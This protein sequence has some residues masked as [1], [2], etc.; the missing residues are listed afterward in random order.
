MRWTCWLLLMLVAFVLPSGCARKA[1]NATLPYGAPV[2]QI[3]SIQVEYPDVETPAHDHI[4]TLDTPPTLRDMSRIEYWDLTLEETVQMALAS[5]RV[6]RDLGGTVVRSPDTTPTSLETSLTE[7]DPRF[8]VSAALSAFD[9]QFNSRLFGEKIDRRLNNRFLGSLGFLQGDNDNWDTQ[10]TKRSA[11]GAQFNLRQHIDFNKDNNPGNQFPDG[12]WNVWYEAEARHPLLQGTGLNFNRIAGPGATPG[13][14]NGVL[15]ARIRT[16]ITLAEFETALRDFTSNVENAY[17]DLYYAYRDL[18][19]K[20]R[21]RDT[22]LETWRRIHALYEAGRRGGEAEKEAQAREQYYRFEADVQDS[23]AGRPLDGTRTNN[24]S[25]AGHLPRL[26]RRA[27]GRAPAAALDEPAA[28]HRQ[29]DPPRRRALA[30]LDRVRMAI[31]RLR[32]ARP[33]QR[34]PPPALAGQTPR[35]GA[36]RQPQLPAAAARC[37]RPVPVSRFWR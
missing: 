12:A 21:A 17:W 3:E 31:D 19:A 29:A 32:S 35:D 18:D 24:G 36:A 1:N 34:A 33:P 30:R 15:I 9:A 20:I 13:T 23:L 5:S 11:T 22:A 37:G 28:E 6:L 26:A 7:T 16:D 10:L 25:L 27:G 2:P 8:G 4:F 14:F